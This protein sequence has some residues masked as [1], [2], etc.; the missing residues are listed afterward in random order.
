MPEQ[1]MIPCPECAKYGLHFPCGNC[2]GSGSMEDR[3]APSAAERAVERIKAR[4]EQ[5]M[6]ADVFHAV[7]GRVLANIIATIINEEAS[8]D[9]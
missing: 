6:D 8:R 7:G 5:E 9:Q 1:K 4:C 3:R 2:D